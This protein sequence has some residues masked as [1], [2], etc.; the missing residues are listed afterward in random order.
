MSGHTQYP[1]LELGASV[2]VVATVDLQVLTLITPTKT[3]QPDCLRLFGK[4]WAKIYQY[5][6]GASLVSLYRSTS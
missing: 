3:Q 4:F 1:T 5:D 6:G 2:S